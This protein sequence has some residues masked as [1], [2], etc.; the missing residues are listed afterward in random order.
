M[1]F[2]L[3]FTKRKLKTFHA[4]FGVITKRILKLNKFHFQN[5]ECKQ[6]VINWWPKVY[7]LQVKTHAMAGMNYFSFTNL[8]SAIEIVSGFSI[9]E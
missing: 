9:L 2:F 6:C 1:Q 8:E 4:T 3:T 7:L 5:N